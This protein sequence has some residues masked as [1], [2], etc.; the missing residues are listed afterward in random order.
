MEYE[1]LLVGLDLL[2]LR[3]AAY[4]HCIFNLQPR[5]L[6]VSYILRVR[7]GAL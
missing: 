2:L 4:R 6:Q 3:T 7:D 1:L 5:G